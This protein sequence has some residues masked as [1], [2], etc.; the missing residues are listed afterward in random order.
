MKLTRGMTAKEIKDKIS[1]AFEVS[2]PSLNVTAMDIVSS[3]SA[4]IRTLMVMLLHNDGGA[5]ISET[6]QVCKF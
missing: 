1:K 6:F 2:T 5:F 4:V 3:L